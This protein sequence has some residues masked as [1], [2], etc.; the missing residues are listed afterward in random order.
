MILFIL[1]LKEL[2]D[3]YWKGLELALE[4]YQKVRKI[5]KSQFPELRRLKRDEFITKLSITIGHYFP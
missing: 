1:N 4:T 3:K 5:V 2:R